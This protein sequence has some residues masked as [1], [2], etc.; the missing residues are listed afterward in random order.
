MALQPDGRIVA[1]GYTS[2]GGGTVQNIAVLRLTSEGLADPAFAPAGRA[3]FDFEGNES[4]YA[5]GS[6][7]P[8]A[9]SCVAGARNTDIFVMRLARRTDAR[10]LHH[11]ADHRRHDVVLVAVRHAQGHGR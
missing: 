6:R 5:R 2:A 4:A 3:I 1:A 8:T 9:E 11:D 10:R 7:R